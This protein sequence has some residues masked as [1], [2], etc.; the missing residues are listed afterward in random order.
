MQEDR[1]VL[2][3]ARL[4]LA[5]TRIVQSRLGSLGHETKCKYHVNLTNTE[6]QDGTEMNSNQNESGTGMM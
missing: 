3:S 4:A 1:R 2:G 5:H 6:P